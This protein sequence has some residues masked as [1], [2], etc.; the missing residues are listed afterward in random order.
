MV[1]S[2]APPATMASFVAFAAASLLHPAAVVTASIAAETSRT[3]RP[4]CV[5]NRIS[6]SSLGP[7]DWRRESIWFVCCFQRGEI[8]AAA[9]TPGLC[10]LTGCLLSHRVTGVRRHGDGHTESRGCGGTERGLLPARLDGSPGNRGQW[11]PGNPTSRVW[12]SAT[13]RVYSTI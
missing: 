10:A 5:V 3:S 8:S 9:L 4:T 6:I 7:L 11:R 2:R 1:I 13:C 12:F